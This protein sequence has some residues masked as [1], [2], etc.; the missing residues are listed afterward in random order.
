MSLE[1]A[2]QTDIKCT[3]ITKDLNIF[4]H[5]PPISITLDITHVKMVTFDGS[6][7]KHKPSRAVGK[8]A[9]KGANPKKKMA[10]GYGW[11]AGKD[12]FFFHGSILK[13]KPSRAVSKPA[14]KGANP[15]KK[16]TA[17]YGWCA[18]KDAFFFFH[19]SI[20]KHKRISHAVATISDIPDDEEEDDDMA[21]LQDSKPDDSESDDDMADLKEREPDH[22]ECVQVQDDEDAP[23]QSPLNVDQKRMLLQS[24]V[25]AS[26]AW[27]DIVKERWHLKSHVDNSKGLRR[28]V[29]S[30]T[31]TRQCCGC[32]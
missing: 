32:I 15:K 14:T 8:P 12:A 1:S 21:D 19:S 25:P 6:I 2:S 13:L 9:A 29:W 17:D 31:Y 27:E 11:C 16:K 23:S 22:S 18:G 28:K 7:L 30:S 10:A 26:M 4:N 24:F 5:L 3:T 20:L